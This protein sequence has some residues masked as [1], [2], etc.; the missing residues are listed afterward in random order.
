M[1]LVN[2]GYEVVEHVYS[3]SECDAI[4]KHL[5]SAAPKS[6]RCMLNLQWCRDI[7]DSL[8]SRI[9]PTLPA[10]TGLTAV[11]RTYSN[12]SQSDNWLVAFHQDRSITVH[13][14]MSGGDFS[15]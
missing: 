9:E 12:K 2:Q 1:T 15:G 3:Q 6:A 8:K 13:P 10:L 14:A 4:G 7:A 5:D 11:Q